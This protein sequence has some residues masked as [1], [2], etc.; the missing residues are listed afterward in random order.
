MDSLQ[1]QR[2]SIQDGSALERRLRLSAKPPDTNVT[3]QKT[4]EI[5]IMKALGATTSQ[6]IWVFMMQGMVVGF[7]GNLTGL[8]LGI[9]AIRYRN[10]F[11]ASCRKIKGLMK[12]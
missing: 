2:P 5:G 8:L 12:T 11:R 1:R 7:F 3:V 10:E 4:R 6:I 9:G